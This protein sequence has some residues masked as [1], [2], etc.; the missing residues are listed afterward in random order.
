AARSWSGTTAGSGQRAP[1]KGMGR[2]SPS[3]SRPFPNAGHREEGRSHS[4]SVP[5]PYGGGTD[6]MRVFLAGASGAVGRPLV[7][8]LTANGH[9]VVGTTRDPRKADLLRSLGA[10]PVVLDVFDRDRLAD[11][12]RE[13]RP[14]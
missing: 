1:A 8:L 12:V 9:E 6:T 5:R 13:A 3:G 14:D 10:N 11:A 4:G 7:S 2:R